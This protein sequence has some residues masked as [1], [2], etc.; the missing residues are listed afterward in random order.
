M[1]I[2]FLTP[3]Q[4]D[5]AVY[6]PGEIGDLPKNAAQILIDGGAAEVFDAAA[7]KAEADAKA[8]AKAEADALATADAES[9]RIAAELA[10]KAQA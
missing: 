2:K 3:V 1:K 7:A 9:A 10:A 5:A 6:A 4:H 8:L